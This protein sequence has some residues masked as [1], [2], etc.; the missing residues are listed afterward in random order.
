MEDKMSN[1]EKKLLEGV[2]GKKE[3]KKAEKNLYLGEFKERVIRYLTYA[4]VMEQGTYPD[5]LEAI[6]KPEARKLII[7]REID[8]Q[9]ANDYI[10]LASANNLQF[11]RVDSP[12]FKGDVALVVVSDQAVEVDERKVLS[13]AERLQAKGISDIII[14]NPGASLC[15]DC[16]RELA[17]KADEELINYKKI[18][19]LDKILGVK[20]VCK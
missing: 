4:Q 19:F 13:R 16:W 7:D 20:C 14:E 8:L 17:G 18:G 15:S 2:H 6:K 12:D 9:A 11:K 5:I 3:L 1:L 10:K